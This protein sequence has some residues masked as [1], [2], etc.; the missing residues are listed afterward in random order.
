MAGVVTEADV[1]VDIHESAH[2]EH[3]SPRITWTFLGMVKLHEKKRS[4]LEEQQLLNV[5]LDKLRATAE[6]VAALQSGLA[7]QEA[8]F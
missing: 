8:L 3:I 2:R 4:E 1:V 6:Q 7:E 5:G